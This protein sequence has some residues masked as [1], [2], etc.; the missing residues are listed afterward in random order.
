MIT[1]TEKKILISEI[2][3]GKKDN[4]LFIVYY[5]I[6]GSLLLAASSKMQVPLMPVPMTLQTMVLLV[7]SM[8]IGWRASLGATLLYVFEGLIGFPVFAKMNGFVFGGGID[9]LSKATG[10]YIVGFVFASTLVG[11]LSEKNWDKSI[12]LTFC[13]MLL[14]TI[15][16]Y[17][18]GV[19]W[20]SYILNDFYKA[21]LG[22]FLPF[23]FT[24]LLKISLGTCLVAACWEISNF[25]KR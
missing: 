24:D 4:L 3:G 2:D 10:G 21:I 11:F 15:I 17:I 19:F 13:A 7:M 9:Y 5:S 1:L 16:I 12:I 18:F 25:L 8:L 20:L 23:I 14:G 22:G 6:I